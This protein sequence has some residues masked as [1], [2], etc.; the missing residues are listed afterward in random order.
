MS[1]P[2]ESRMRVVF[3]PENHRQ[4]PIHVI[5]AGTL[6]SWVVQLL[7]KHGLEDI[8]VHDPDQ[9]SE[10]NCTS[11][12]YGLCHVGQPKVQ[13]LAAIIKVQCGIDIRVF[14]ERVDA[15]T[16]L[17]GI[18]FVCVDDMEV[19]REI[20]N[21][22]IK[23]NPAVE[24]MIEGRMLSAN[25]RVYAI[26]P[27]VEPEDVTRWESRWYPQPEALPGQCSE[28]V[29]TTAFFISGAMVTQFFHWCAIQDGVQTR[30]AWELILS[31]PSGLQ[32][33]SGGPE[34]FEV[35]STYAQTA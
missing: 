31:L 10:P 35:R 15:S 34:L 8:R 11:S 25:G 9:V 13:A 2:D 20:F 26:Q 24:L 23:T 16:P 14:Q 4:R 32:V 27:W 12:I 6:G 5:G 21:G 33:Q 19:R 3:H 22:C 18:V 28:A 30:L 17:E 1:M 7:A 29:G